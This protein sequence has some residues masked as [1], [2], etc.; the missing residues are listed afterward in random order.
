MTTIISDT[1]QTI[2]D[3]AD[4]LI[5]GHDGG[6]LIESVPATLV[7]ADITAVR[8]LQ[9]LIARK[10]GAVGGWKVMAGGE[11][12]PFCAPIPASRYF[13]DGK[14]IN[15]TRYRI[16]LVE[17]EIAVKL[18][19]DLPAE[20]DAA[21]VEAAIISVHPALE[22]I[23]SPFVDRDAIDFNTKLADLQSNGAVVVGPAFADDTKTQFENIP[24]ALTHDGEVVKSGQGGAG[25][26]QIVD[27][28][29]WLATHAAGRGMP[30]KTG[31][32]IITG[33]RVLAPNDTAKS[34]L[35]QFGE[36]GSVKATL[37]HS[38]P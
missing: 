38:E 7:P 11:G 20:A 13:A 2:D 35:G 15:A 16:M 4:A 26:S 22:L 1:L 17:L 10:S 18:G 24:A 19:R 36:H 23:G 34:V 12:E 6:P 8:T 31:D 32:V 5:A 25:W 27:A 29:K 33:S 28:V 14:S 9:D 37:E 21:T 30:L 3:L